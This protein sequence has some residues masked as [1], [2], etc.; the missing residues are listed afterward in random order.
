MLQMA[1]PFLNGD[2][3]M[4]GSLLII[5]ADD[6]AAAQ[7]LAAEDPYAKAGLFSDVRIEAWKKVIG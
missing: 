5:E 4:C 6:I 1:G 7:A 2:D 3:A